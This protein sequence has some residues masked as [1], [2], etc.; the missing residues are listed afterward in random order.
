MHELDKP[1][2]KV[3]TVFLLVNVLH[4]YGEIVYDGHLKG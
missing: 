3:E 2:T 1:D 4:K